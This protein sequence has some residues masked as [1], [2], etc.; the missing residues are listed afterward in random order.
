M[1]SVAAPARLRENIAA[2]SV[3]QGLNY[4]VPLVT[5]PYLVRVLGPA[6]FGLITFA[7]ALI[8]YFD[9]LTNYGFSFSATRTVACCQ[10]SPEAVAHVF[11]RTT[12]A[13]AALMLLSAAILGVLVMAIPRFRAT[14]LLYAASFLTVVGTVTF[15]VW[16]FQGIEQMRFI[17]LAQAS[18]RLLSI[19]ALLIVVRSPADYVYAAA[20]QG[21]V[22]VLAGIFL[23]PALLRRVRSGPPRP[24]VSD[25]WAA[26]RE[27]WH[28]FVAQ[29]GLVIN[30]STTTV[31]LGLVSGNS[32]VGYFG[33]A[34]KV[35]KAMTSLLAPV[36]QALYP[37][38]NALKSRSRQ[39]TLGLMR[40][41]FAWAGAMALA[42]SV[43]TLFLAR[44]AG[45]LLWGSGFYHSIAVLRCLSP[46]PLLF[47]LIDIVGVQTMLVL[48]MDSVL[49]RILFAGAVLNV[50]LAAV[51]SARF[52]ALG[53]AAATVATA[54]MVA[55]SLAWRIARVRALVTWA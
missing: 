28:P 9:L 12:Y 4:A 13:K 6:H 39:L 2:L 32:E 29:T 23:A 41:A 50:G 19:P 16:F 18:A 33:A 1:S 11:W 35:I 27:G 7:Q 5:V 46:L 24:S 42:A 44:P 34:D 21:G 40:K 55:V 26:L 10:E 17:T 51:L 53:A 14:P 47:A 3:L 8:I 49:S 22:P 52:G 30:S 36:A 54:F 20:I 31:V 48:E 43:A 45:L 25:T 38:L 15:P 37:R